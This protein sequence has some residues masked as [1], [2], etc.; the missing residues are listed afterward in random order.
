MCCGQDTGKGIWRR[1]LTISAIGACGSVADGGSCARVEQATQGRR[2]AQ[3]AAQEEPLPLPRLRCEKQK[4]ST[5]KEGG[6]AEA[7]RTAH[8]PT[9]CPSSL[10]L[11]TDM[12]CSGPHVGRGMPSGTLQMRA[13]THCTALLPYLHCVTSMSI[14]P[15]C[16]L[17]DDRI[18]MLQITATSLQLRSY[19]VPSSLFHTV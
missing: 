18:T 14:A 10:G 11:R 6:R 13:K 8:F 4:G 16:E 15:L 5:C 7:C 3:L 2:G 9:R 17:H 1:A 12:S 19:S